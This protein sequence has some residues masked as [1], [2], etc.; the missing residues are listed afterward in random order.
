MV[1]THTDHIAADTGSSIIVCR[2]ACRGQDWSV[3]AH[4][5]TCSTTVAGV[6][7]CNQQ[8]PTGLMPNACTTFPHYAA[9]M[10]M[11]SPACQSA[12]CYYAAHKAVFRELHPMP[13]S[14]LV[15]V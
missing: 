3:M 11:F 12:I 8:L 5:S 13:T 1:L 9:M 7:N 15:I 14:A 2:Q 10:H 6:G 4:C